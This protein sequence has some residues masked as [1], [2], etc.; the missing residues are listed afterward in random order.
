MDLA[1][2]PKNKPSAKKFAPGSSGPSAPGNC[3]QGAQRPA[4]DA[5]RHA[6]LGQ[7]SRQKGWLG[8]GWPKSSAARA[9]Q[10]CKSTCLKKKCALAGAPR[11]VPFGPVMVAPSSWPHGNAEQQKRFPARHRQRRSV[12]EPGLQRTGL[13]LGPGQRQDPRRARGR[14]VH[15]Q[16]PENLDH[17]GP[18]WRLDVQPRTAPATRGKPQTGISFL[19]LDMKSGVTVRPSSCSMANAKS[20]VFFD[21]VEVPP[22][23]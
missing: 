13:R 3:R 15:R 17:P 19:L 22:R 21:N 16:R 2:T 14:Q 10:P 9:G 11:I 23:T 4:P 6:E 8:S 20:T 12:V 1:F 5:R 7:N 18:V